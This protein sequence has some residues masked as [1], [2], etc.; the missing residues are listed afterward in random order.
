[1]LNESMKEK[2]VVKIHEQ[3]LKLFNQQELDQKVQTSKKAVDH[4]EMTKDDNFFLHTLIDT[5]RFTKK[6]F[7]KKNL[8]PNSETEPFLNLDNNRMPVSVN[9]STNFDNLYRN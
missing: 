9:D 3:L 7:K 5:R 8:K 1:M 2:M 4:D 6:T